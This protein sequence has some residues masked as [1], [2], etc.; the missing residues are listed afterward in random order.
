MPI[1]NMKTIVITENQLKKVVDV[2]KEQK[3][4]DAITKYQKEQNRQISM[5][6]DDAMLLLNLG[7]SW[8]EGKSD[9]PDC[10][11][12]HRLRSKLNLFH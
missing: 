12:I 9:H 7:Q 11:E 3:F 2:V 5:S 1:F 10:E 8:C 4:D 6:Q